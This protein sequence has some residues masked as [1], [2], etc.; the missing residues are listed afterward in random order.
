[1]TMAQ[2]KQFVITKGIIGTPCIHAVCSLCPLVHICSSYTTYE[3]KCQQRY[4]W[5]CDNTP[6]YELMDWV[7]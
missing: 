6:Y 4:Q 7:L 2:I 1:M 3:E 5:V